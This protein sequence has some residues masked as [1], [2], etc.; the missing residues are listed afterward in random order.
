MKTLLEPVISNS[1]IRSNL[2]VI[3]PQV[4]RGMISVFHMLK[5]L[6]NFATHRSDNN[7]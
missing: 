4:K 7:K 1:K 3:L 5:C 2:D 6:S